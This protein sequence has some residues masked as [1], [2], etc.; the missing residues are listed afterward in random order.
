[1][2]LLVDFGNKLKMLRSQ[3]HLTQT[4]V[5]ERVNITKAMISAYETGTR[6]PSYD[7]LIK[8][9]ALFRVTT[10]YL[11]CVEDKRLIDV[12]GLNEQEIEVVINM[13][14]ILKKR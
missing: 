2:T 1:M 7:I 3:K 12:T 14:D 9:A 11:L 10:D 13:V 4:Q 6:F 5:A 8:L